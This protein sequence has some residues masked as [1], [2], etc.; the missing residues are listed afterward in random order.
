ML[1]ASNGIEPGATLSFTLT[2]A[3]NLPKTG[4]NISS[5]PWLMFLIATFSMG[6]VLHRRKTQRGKS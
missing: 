3:A 2:V 5:L 4:E 1:T 6:I